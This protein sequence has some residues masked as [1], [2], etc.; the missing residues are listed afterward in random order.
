[1]VT[2]SK[3]ER[4]HAHYTVLCFTFARMCVRRAMTHLDATHWTLKISFVNVHWQR[5]SERFDAARRCMAEHRQHHIVA[6]AAECSE[7]REQAKL[8]RRAL[9]RMRVH[10]FSVKQQR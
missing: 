2:L 4:A 6:R 1:M 10:H 8:W 3:H 7:A 5:V 9:L